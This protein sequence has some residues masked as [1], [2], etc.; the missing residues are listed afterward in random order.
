MFVRAGWCRPQRI[1][2][3]VDLVHCIARRARRSRLVLHA[4]G[5]FI[6]TCTGVNNAFTPPGTAVR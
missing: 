2:K 3:V 4:L 1:S 6:G 5:G